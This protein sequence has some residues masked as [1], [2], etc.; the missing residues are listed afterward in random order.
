MQYAFRVASAFIVAFYLTRFISGHNE[1]LM[2]V[3]PLMCVLLMTRLLTW[4]RWPL[5]PILPWLWLQLTLLTWAIF[6]L[7]YLEF[8][9]LSSASN[10]L[11]MASGVCDHHTLVLYLR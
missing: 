7:Y 2:W 1:A 4:L 11:M 5:L 10:L 3:V 9:A 8:V 6:S